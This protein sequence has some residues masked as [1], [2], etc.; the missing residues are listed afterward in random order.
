MAKTPEGVVKDACKKYLKSIGCWYFMPVSNGMGM[1]GILDLN[2]CFQ[3]RFVA[4]ETKAPGKLSN[5]TA[6]QDR[7]IAEIKAA[8]GLAIVVDNVEQ[9]KSFFKDHFGVNT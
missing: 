2:C 3:G 9:V 6:N 1:V 8:G 5:T 4:I 7:V